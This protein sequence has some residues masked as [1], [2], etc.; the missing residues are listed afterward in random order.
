MLFRS[1]VLETLDDEPVFASPERQAVFE[2][3]ALHPHE[4]FDEIPEELQKIS[5]YVKI[6]S[7]MAEELYSAFDANERLREAQDL[8]RRLQKDY[9]KT[10]MHKLTE[11]IRSAESQGDVE[12]VGLL[13]SR[14]NELIGNDKKE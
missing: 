9:K 6:L 4:K 11:A 12:A 7:L 14:F 10:E 1:R 2:Y 8:V 5:D 3:I 13:L